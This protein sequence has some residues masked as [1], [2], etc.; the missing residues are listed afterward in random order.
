MYEVTLS[1]RNAM[2]ARKLLERVVSY[3]LIDYID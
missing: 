2:P 3:I 1:A